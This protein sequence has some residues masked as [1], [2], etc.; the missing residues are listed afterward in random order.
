MDV[1]TNKNLVR[2]ATYVNSNTSLQIMYF[3]YTWEINGFTVRE[4]WHIEA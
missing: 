2:M 1:I 3:N 4:N